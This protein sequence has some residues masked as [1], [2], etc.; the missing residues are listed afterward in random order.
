MSEKLICKKDSSGSVTLGFSVPITNF[1]LILTVVVCSVW[2]WHWLFRASDQWATTRVL[3]LLIPLFIIL[4]RRRQ[5]KTLRG[6]QYFFDA[7]GRVVLKNGE[8][9]GH[10]ENVEAVQIRRGSNS[11]GAGSIPSYGISLIFRHGS[12][13]FLAET[14]DQDDASR[15]A[16]M[17]AAVIGVEV[18]E[19]E[20]N[21]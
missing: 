10:F 12:R 11:G 21:R 9:V 16:R 18:H 6:L 15:A 20:G 2:Y 5:L 7:S 17:I 13:F 4:S 3:A 8:R 19:R 1:S 14:T